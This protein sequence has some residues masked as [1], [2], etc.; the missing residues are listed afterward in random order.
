MLYHHNRKLDKQQKID[1]IN[2]KLDQQDDA[3]SGNPLPGKLPNIVMLS[4]IQAAWTG[5]IEPL[6]KLY[7]ELAPFLV[8]RKRL[9]RRRMDTLT[10]V[11]SD[12]VRIRTHWKNHPDKKIQ[13][14]NAAIEI[15]IARHDDRST[16][17]SSQ[18]NIDTVLARLKPSGAHRK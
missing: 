3:V 8:A 2:S 12:V 11:A 5:N 17:Y 9:K 14:G 15:A 18:V 16:Q 7:P 1:W 10:V 6:R 4:A 13:G